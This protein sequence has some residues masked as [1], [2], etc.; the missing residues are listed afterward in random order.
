VA[1][2]H[3]AQSQA[4]ARAVAAEARATEAEARAAAAIQEAK[5]RVT[6]AEDNAVTADRDFRRLRSQLCAGCRLRLL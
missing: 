3:E 6:V 2:A 1:A 4:E 5:A